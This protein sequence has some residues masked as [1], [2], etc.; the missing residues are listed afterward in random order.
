M[1]INKLLYLSLICMLLFSCDSKTVYKKFSNN[2]S[3]NRWPKTD[4]LT[5]KFTIDEPGMYDILIDYSHVY[6]T[7]LT[8]IPLHVSVEQ[9]GNVLW[10]EP[11][12]IIIRDEDGNQIGDCTG[13]YCDVRQVISENKTLLP[14]EYKVHLRNEFNFDYLPNILGIG[15]RVARSEAAQ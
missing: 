4:V 12:A 15:I 3:D 6:D 9:S 10:E 13:D 8:G 2:F 1:H 14:G 11:V 5:Y 7:P